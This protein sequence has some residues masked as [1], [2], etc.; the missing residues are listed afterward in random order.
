MCVFGCWILTHRESIPPRN[1]S[2]VKIEG[3]NAKQTQSF[4][5]HHGRS[6][7][8]RGGA[9][10]AEEDVSRHACVG[11]GHLDVFLHSATVIITMLLG[12]VYLSF[13]IPGFNC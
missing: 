13:C 3:R 2:N 4:V 10:E 8:D 9:G 1:N 5:C 6:D 7:Y 12:L 11:R